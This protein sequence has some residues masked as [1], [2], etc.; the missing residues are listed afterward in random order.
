MRTE[1][2]FLAARYQIDSGVLHP[3]TEGPLLPRA[4]APS[5]G[6][7]VERKKFLCN[8]SSVSKVL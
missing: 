3:L 4:S 1:G 5:P 6:G 7:S 2:R 8:Q